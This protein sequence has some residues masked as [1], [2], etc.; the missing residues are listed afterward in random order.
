MHYIIYDLEATCWENRPTNYEQEIIE[1]GAVMLNG[2][3]E[4]LGTFNRFVRPILHPDLSFYCK[5]LTNIDQAVIN[6]ASDFQ[7]VIEEFQDWAEVF[8]EDY[9]LCAWGSFDEKILRKDCILHDVET[10]WLEEKCLNIKR[11][12]QEIKRLRQPW[13]LK[14]AVEKSGFEFEGEPHRA[15]NDAINLTKIFL[16]NRDEWRY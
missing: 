5:N 15:I 11:Q 2:Y 8:Y 14:K 9:L 1:I 16:E 4:A 7:T 3:G 13:G 10:D 6:R 12:F